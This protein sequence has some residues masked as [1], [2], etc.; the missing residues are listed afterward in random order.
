MHTLFSYIETTE[1]IP[2]A[3]DR[4]I[5]EGI[6]LPGEKKEYSQKIQQHISDSQVED[7]F[8]GKYKTYAECAVLVEENGEV[9]TQRPDR[10]LFSD[11][12]TL[13]ID[14]KF[15]EQ[16]SEHKNQMQR[17]AR[18][19]EQ[20]NRKNIRTFIWYVEKNEIIHIQRK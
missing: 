6:I 19:L 20:M 9:T 5:F 12:E 10:V 3:L 13:I 2:V 4:L 15:G 17:Y 11:E 16:R 14:Y 18:L 1:D 7:W 8:S